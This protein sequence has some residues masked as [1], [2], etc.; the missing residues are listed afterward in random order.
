GATW[1]LTPTATTDPDAFLT[2]RSVVSGLGANV[3]AV[4]PD[5]HDELVALVSHVPHLTAATLMDLAADTS[6][7]HATLLRL[8]A[9]GFRDMT[10]IAAGH[11]GIWPD[12]CA[13][14]RVAIVANLDRLV[15][16]LAALRAAVVEAGR[17]WLLA[18]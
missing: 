14:N 1:V 10:R 6:E 17:G 13:D 11:P 8:A 2:I 18:G 12:I 5:R 3:V 7:E 4:E 9:G 15:E 16:A